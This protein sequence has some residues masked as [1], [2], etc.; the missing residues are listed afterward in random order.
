MTYDKLKEELQS[1]K[2]RKGQ[3]GTDPEFFLY[4]YKKF[5]YI[6]AGEVLPDEDIVPKGFPAVTDGF[7]GEIH[8]SPTTC[9]QIFVSNV[10]KGIAQVIALLA[11]D[12]RQ[13]E[14]RLNPVIELSDTDLANL[15]PGAKQFGCAPSK[16][17]Y[18]EKTLKLDG[19][20]HNLRYSGGHL[21]FSIEDY[22]NFNPEVA[23][24]LMDVFVGLPSV[25]IAYSSKQEKIRRKYYGRAG[26]YRYNEKGRILEYRV[27]SAIWMSSTAATSLMPMYGR[28]A[29]HVM[30]SPN[31]ADLLTTIDFDKVR[32]AINEC[33]YDLALNLYQKY[34]M[35]LDPIK[36]IQFISPLKLK[37]YGRIRDCICPKNWAIIN[38]G[39][40]KD[41]GYDTYS[42]AIRKDPTPDILGEIARIYYHNPSEMMEKLKEVQ[43]G[44]F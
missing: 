7:Q 12:K 44:R 24:K 5:K 22:N 35:P 31:A 41:R 2:Y 11:R 36:W 23:I 25:I 28:M 32:L 14:I 13:C 1:R 43:D 8:T 10:G 29:L 39:F 38:D 3:L 37:K 9:R 16:S 26:E 27:P 20:K 19:S 40:N 18:N 33:N 42:L 21:H 17:A 34:V 6:E 15:S 4:D 30:E